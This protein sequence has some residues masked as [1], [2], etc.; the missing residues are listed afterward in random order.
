MAEISSLCVYCGSSA[1]GA[2]SHMAAADKLGHQLAERGITLIYGG[3]RVGVMGRI[4][5][6]TLADGGEVVGIIPRFLDEYEIGHTDLTRLEIC[7]SMH[8][9]KARMADLSD[10]FIVLPGGLGTLEELFETLTWKQLGLHTKPIVVVDQD[11]YWQP[12]RALI[13][14]IIEQGYARQENA[15]LL[16][17]VATVDDIFPALAK[18]P[19]GVSKVDSKWL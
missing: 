19:S 18:L 12:V 14:S 6:A 16:T 4:A 15:D 10:G 11:G 9:R 8:E 3:G 17:F 5:D 7:D 2:K 13:D 1:R